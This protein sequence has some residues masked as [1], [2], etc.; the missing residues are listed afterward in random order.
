MRWTDSKALPHQT[1]KQDRT[2]KVLLLKFQHKLKQIPSM[3]KTTF[4][5]GIPPMADYV[6]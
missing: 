6:P 4:K 2:A 5:E 1:S 3:Q